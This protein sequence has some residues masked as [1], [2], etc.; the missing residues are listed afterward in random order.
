M[1]TCP[2]CGA[3]LAPTAKFC[4]KCDTQLAAQKVPDQTYSSAISSL[5]GD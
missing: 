2:N 5:L 4:T 3:S 1:Q